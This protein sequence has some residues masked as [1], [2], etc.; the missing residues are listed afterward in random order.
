MTT[1]RTF[2]TQ[3]ENRSFCAKQHKNLGLC[4]TSLFLLSA[5]IFHT[6][7]RDAG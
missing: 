4:P 5:S 6:R 7:E 2:A 3:H 1:A